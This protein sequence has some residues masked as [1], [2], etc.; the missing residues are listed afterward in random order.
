MT[1]N[2]I[3][4][5]LVNDQVGNAIKALRAAKPDDDIVLNL[6]GQWNSLQRSITAGRISHENA[7]LSTNQIRGG[8]MD[9]T[10]ELPS[11]LRV[12]V[13]LDPPTEPLNTKKEGDSASNKLPKVFLSYSQK[14]MPQAKK[15]REFLGKNGIQVTIDSEAMELGEDIESFI[16][17]SIKETDITL[18]LVSKNS[19]LSA[20]VGMESMNMLTAEKIT[21]KKYLAVVADKSFFEPKFVREAIGEIDGK[22]KELD[23]EI[24][25]RRK[26]NIGIEDIQGDL[27]R[28]SKLRQGLTTII[29][30]LKT[31]LHANI[32]GENFDEGMAKVLK[33]IKG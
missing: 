29:A 1:K 17:K 24:S 16:Y 12:E 25:F 8:L 31:R 19:L 9:I 20:W 15:V 26:E 30:N 5:L 23:E 21:D 10:K 13:A 7:V 28:L 6:A 27:T 2:D 32:E 4:E 18:S 11:D 14:D 33:A 22:I 3:L